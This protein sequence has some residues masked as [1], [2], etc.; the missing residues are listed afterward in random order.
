MKKIF[1]SILSVYLSASVY[2]AVTT[3]EVHI[4]TGQ[5]RINDGICH[6][7]C[8]TLNFN[9]GVKTTLPCGAFCKCTDGPKASI[10]SL[11]DIAQEKAN[12]PK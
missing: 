2:A 3:D 12:T 11:D 1:I 7:I 4:P 9:S 6:Q 8:L 10:R 5:Q